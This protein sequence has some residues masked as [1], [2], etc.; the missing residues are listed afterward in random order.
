MLRGIN[1]SGQKRIR[2]DELRG[3]MARQEQEM[4]ELRSMLDQTKSDVQ[5][6]LEIEQEH[7]LKAIDE[8]PGKEQETS[9]SAPDTKDQKGPSN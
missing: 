1:V 8:Q 4:R 9:A 3:M 5:D 7:L 6:G 2:M